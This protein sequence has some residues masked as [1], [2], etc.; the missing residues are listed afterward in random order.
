MKFCLFDY[1]R[2]VRFDKNNRNKEHADGILGRLFPI[3][4]AIDLSILYLVCYSILL[5]P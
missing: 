5:A 4:V 3:V 1:F 2:F